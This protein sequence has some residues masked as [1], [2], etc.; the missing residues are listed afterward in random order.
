M[1]KLPYCFYSSFIFLVNVF[2]AA[3]Y[4]YY[5]YSWLFSAL[6]ITSIIYHCDYNNM[7]IKFIDKIAISLIVL[8]G[9]YLFLSKLAEKND[10]KILPKIGLSL[11]ILGTFFSTIYLYCYGYFT[12]QFCFCDD[13]DI[14]CL[15]HCLLHCCG[16][17]GHICIVL[18]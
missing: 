17:F 5:I 14:A 9:G 2:I 1:E 11:F 6:F 7:T 3:H 4:K 16:S 8:S 15:W 10:R 13:F 12:K 18:L